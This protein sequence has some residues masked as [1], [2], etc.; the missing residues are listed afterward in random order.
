MN[1]EGDGLSKYWNEREELKVQ[2]R[3]QRMGRQR[4]CTVQGLYSVMLGAVQSICNSIR[5]S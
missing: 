4:P 5:S 3:D 2:G 1:V